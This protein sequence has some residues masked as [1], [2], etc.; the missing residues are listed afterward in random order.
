MRLLFLLFLVAGAALCI[1]P[2]AVANFSGSEIGTWS[3][4]EAGRFVPVEVRLKPSDA[5]VRVMAD[6]TIWRPHAVQSGRAQL[7]VTAIHDG[8][9]AFENVL[10]FPADPM[11][12]QRSPQIT[13]RVF[14]ADGG[15]IETVEAG[16]YRFELR[17]GNLVD[18]D[19]K[20]VELVLRRESGALDS[21][22][23]PAGLSLMGI[24][25][26]GLVLAFRNRRRQPKNPNSQPPR[27]GRGNGE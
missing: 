16:T 15:L 8:R 24:G 11:P 21:R 20:G 2:W 13:E 1:H 19:I 18:A 10:K 9:T 6:M 14:R 7:D 27:W 5:P 12:R 4:Y 25:V 26:V 22:M 23:Q 3:V 17:R